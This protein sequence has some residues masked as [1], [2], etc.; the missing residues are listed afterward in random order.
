MP[1]H[2]THTPYSHT[3]LSHKH[4]HY[5]I[6]LSVCLSFSLS[7]SLSLPP[8]FSLS[9]YELF[10]MTEKGGQS[11]TQQQKHCG[12]H[13]QLKAEMYTHIQMP[14]HYTHTL[15]THTMMS[16]KHTNYF[17]SF[18]HFFS[19]TL[20]TFSLTLSLSLI[21]INHFK[22]LRKEDSQLPSSRSTVGATVS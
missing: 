19:L 5:L 6:S 10:Q 20:T 17:L 8:S 18:S 14:P 11:V 4:T 2:Y 12:C 22:R 9:L 13:C 16:H 1:L 21:K 15:L 7:L 3:I